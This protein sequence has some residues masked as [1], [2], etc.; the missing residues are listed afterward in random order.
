MFFVVGEV[1]YRVWKRREIVGGGGGIVSFVLG[2]IFVLWFFREGELCC[3]NRL[4]FFD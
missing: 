3:S 1:G 2:F 4:V